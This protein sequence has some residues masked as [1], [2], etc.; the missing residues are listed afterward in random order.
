[1]CVCVQI[2][3]FLHFPSVLRLSFASILNQTA[4]VS[5]PNPHMS[6]VRAMCRV[7]IRTRV[8]AIGSRIVIVG[9]ILPC[10]FWNSHL[11]NEFNACVHD[12]GL[13]SCTHHSVFVQVCVP[14]R[15]CVCDVGL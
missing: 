15:P 12:Y 8:F 3:E 13:G 7:F 9:A 5:L 4:G 1:M 11:Q 2:K 10:L 14:V 6:P